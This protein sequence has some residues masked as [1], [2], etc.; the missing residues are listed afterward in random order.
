M[1]RRKCNELSW[2]WI[3]EERKL[4]CQSDTS[5]VQYPTGLGMKWA[6]ECVT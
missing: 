6:K 3:V 2:A 1:Q 4:R 5:K